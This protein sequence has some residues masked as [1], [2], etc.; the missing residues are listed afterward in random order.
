MQH[1]KFMT[2]YNKQKKYIIHIIQKTWSIYS[3][4]KKFHNILLAKNMTVDNYFEEVQIIWVLA[5]GVQWAVLIF[6][7]IDQQTMVAELGSLLRS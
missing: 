7:A 5:S 3:I 6:I 4:R 2:N 1:L